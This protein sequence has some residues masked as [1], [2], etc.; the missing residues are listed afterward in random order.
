M[1]YGILAFGAYVPRL[2][3]QRKA[4]AD[5]HG[6]FNAALK[7]Q[8][9]G[10]R[11]IANW[12]E[13]A[14]TMAVE[15]ARDCLTG[16]DASRIEAVQM[17]STTFPFLDRLNSGVVA[18]ALNLGQDIGASDAGQTQRAAT[19]ALMSAL[20][21]GPSTLLVAAEKR[22]VKAAS[23]MEMTAG[24]GAAAL[25]VGEGRPVAQKFSTR[26]TGM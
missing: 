15:A 2:R 20:R 4:I 5:A 26:V 24:D 8:G 16:Q 18:E 7:G 14:V 21:G 17:A 3:L 23:P 1:T 13:D 9:K 25:L 6:W 11:A 22:P 10:E 12:D 19:S